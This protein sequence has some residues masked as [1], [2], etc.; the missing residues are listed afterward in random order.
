MNN[1]SE[2]DTIIGS[3]DGGKEFL[4]SMKAGIFWYIL[5]ALSLSTN[6]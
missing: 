3:Y 6:M 5:L 1:V 2:Y 4:V